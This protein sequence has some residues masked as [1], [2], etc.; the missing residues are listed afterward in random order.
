MLYSRG[1]AGRGAVDFPLPFVI[2]TVKNGCVGLFPVHDGNPAVPAGVFIMLIAVI[3]LRGLIAGV[4][5]GIAV[6]IR[7]FLKFRAVVVREGDLRGL[8]DKIDSVVIVYGLF[9]GGGAVQRG[10]IHA[11]V[12][13]VIIVGVA[14]AHPAQRDKCLC[15]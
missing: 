5:R 2:D 6:I 13:V 3:G 9:D 4:D 10:G 11:A 12:R 15:Q 14:E 7:R 8:F 1:G